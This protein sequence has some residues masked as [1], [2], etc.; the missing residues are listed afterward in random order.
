M[1]NVCALRVG[2]PVR[3]MPAA[4]CYS[5]LVFHSSD[6]LVLCSCLQSQIVYAC[7]SEL[8]FVCLMVLKPLC[9]QTKHSI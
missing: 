8:I 4:Q 9:G 2:T 6:T 3:T 5:L 7:N 1:P